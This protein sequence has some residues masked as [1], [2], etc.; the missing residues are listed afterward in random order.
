MEVITH[1]GQ[2]KLKAKSLPESGK[3]FLCENIH[4]LQP[5]CLTVVEDLNKNPQRRYKPTACQKLIAFSPNR[6]GISQFHNN[7]NGNPMLY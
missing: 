4:Q 6:A 2:R 3:T 1:F 7:I 5:L